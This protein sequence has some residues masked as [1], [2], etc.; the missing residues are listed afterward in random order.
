MT[1]ATCTMC[2]GTGWYLQDGRTQ[3]ACT[4]GCSPQPV[5]HS[6]I[7]VARMRRISKAPISVEFRPVLI[8]WATQ[9]ASHRADMA[10]H[11]RSRG[12]L[13]SPQSV[14]Q[15]VDAAAAAG[16]GDQG[17]GAQGR[18]EV[19]VALVFPADVAMP[20]PRRR[21]G[22]IPCGECHLQDDEVCDICGAL[23]PAT[24]QGDTK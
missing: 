3:I 2:G 7:V 20:Q 4:Q 12:L 14:A 23:N 19:P 18:D 11:W 24:D 9:R 16:G 15:G 17:Q 21:D 8:T 6:S 5:D 22:Q 13:P 1:M 10:D